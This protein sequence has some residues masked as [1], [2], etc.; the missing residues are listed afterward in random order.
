MSPSFRSGLPMVLPPVR[1][2]SSPDRRGRLACGGPPL[3]TAGPPSG[4]EEASM[5]LR[6]RGRRLPGRVALLHGLALL[7]LAG[8]AGAQPVE[9]PATWG[10]SL[11]DRPRLTGSW[12]GV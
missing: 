1:A 6:T 2:E 5:H 11:S 9:V 4:L 8:S 7:L 3:H 10:G 12:F